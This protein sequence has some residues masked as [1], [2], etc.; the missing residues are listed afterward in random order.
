[1]LRRVGTSGSRQHSPL[2]RF[3]AAPQLCMISGSSTTVA[4]EKGGLS[5]AKKIE[6]DSTIQY[7]NRCDGVVSGSKS[8]CD[9]GGHRS[10]P[11]R[12]CSIANLEGT[13]VF[14]RTG[15]NNVVG[16]PIAGIGIAVF[17]GDG[18]R[19]PIR[20]TR[21]TNGEIR[22]WTD[23][24]PSGSYTIDPDCTGSFLVKTVQKLKTSSSLTEAKSSSCLVWRRTPLPQLKERSSMSTTDRVLSALYAHSIPILVIL[25]KNPITALKC[26]DYH[27]HALAE[28][29]LY[30]RLLGKSPGFTTVEIFLQPLA[31]LRD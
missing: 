11:E 2:G 16:G 7:R 6:V 12:G 18:T 14:R 24:P 25:Q 23:S 9:T 10:R 19:G 29:A 13:Y 26:G 30:L 4:D 28:F 27:A 5:N 20:S 3:L 31:F 1:M 17:N 21:S 22:D 15:V 8:P